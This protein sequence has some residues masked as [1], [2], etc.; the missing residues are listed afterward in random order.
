[1]SHPNKMLPRAEALPEYVPAL[2]D[3][4]RAF[5]NGQP[6]DDEKKTRLAHVA[7]SLGHSAATLSRD[8]EAVREALKQHHLDRLK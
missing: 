2:L 1:M 4:V 7:V 3:I 8:V 5:E 6:A